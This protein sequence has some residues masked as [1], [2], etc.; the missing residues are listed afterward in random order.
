MTYA[1]TVKAFG[2]VSTTNIEATSEKEAEAHALKAVGFS[3]KT[4]RQVG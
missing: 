2:R 3:V 1:L 4:K